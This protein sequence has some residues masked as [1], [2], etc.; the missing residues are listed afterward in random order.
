MEGKSRL[1][2]G[3]RVLHVKR[4]GKGHLV[5]ARGRDGESGA[6]AEAIPKPS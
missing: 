6:S 3:V 2:M 5:T 1:Q 4:E